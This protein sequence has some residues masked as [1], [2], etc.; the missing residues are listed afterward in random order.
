MTVIVDD[1]IDATYVI[2]MD[3]DTRRLSEF[4]NMMIGSNWSYNRFSGINGKKLLK[5]EEIELQNTY[6]KKITWL[7]ASEI[8]C[9]LS[10]V[11]LWEKVATDANLQRI[12]IFED[13]ARTYTDGA[14]I[15]KIITDFYDYLSIASE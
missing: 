4:H 10:H 5:P 13:D 9:L 6:V 2:N 3:S 15:K 12:L 7:S 1:Y 11:S 14:T 8:G